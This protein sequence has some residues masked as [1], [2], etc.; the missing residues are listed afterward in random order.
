[1]KILYFLI[2][3][4][5]VTFVSAQETTIMGV[6]SDTQN[7]PLPGVNIV[8]K[9]TNNGVVTDFDGNYSIAEVK[10]NDVLVFS[11]LGFGSQEVIVSGQNTI[12]IQLTEESEA[13][14]QIVVIGYGG[15]KQKDVTG[16]VSVV[17]S[18]TL[19]KLKPV[20]VGQALQGRAS[21]VAVT[22]SSGSPG[23]D[24]NI[25]IR[26][27]GSNGDNGPLI[28]V[29]GY[30]G[31]LSS[32]N[33]NDVESISILKDAQAAIYG[34]DGANGV[35]LVTTKRGK[36]NSKPTFSYNTYTGFQE[37]TR[38]LPLL[39]A[40]EYGVLLNEGYAAAGRPIPYPNLSELG[41]GTD[42]QDL[43][44][45]TSPILSHN[46]NFLINV[47]DTLNSSLSCNSI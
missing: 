28:I 47:I 40:T 21:G 20:E 22:A 6:V 31:D 13:L 4:F 7:I 15:Q 23:A 34:I 3:V 46:L 24:L 33:P 43:L 9:G 45:D 5:L 19:E 42:W 8:V 29:D 37:T 26:G 30:R 11:F 39:D 35:V 17:S 2:A 41:I 32:I 10:Q 1:M 14:E 12:D 44:F 18:K 27:I 36:R 38:K 16:S 25:T